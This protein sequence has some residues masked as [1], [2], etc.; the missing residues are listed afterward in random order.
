MT[1]YIEKL[2]IEKPVFG[3][4]GLGFHEG[5]AVFVPNALIGDIVRVK[6]K[7]SKKG[8]LFG[9]IEDYIEHSP[10]YTKPIC[11]VFGRCG[12]C[13]WLNLPYLKQ[14]EY[15]TTIVKEILHELDFPIKAVQGSPVSNF[16][17]NKSFLPISGS[18]KEPKIGMFAGQTHDVIE[19]E[20]C[21]LH[22]KVFDDIADLIKA[23]IIKA[24]V[25][26]YDE[27]SGKG[28]LRHLGIRYSE[29]TGQI[30][31]ILV[32][33]TK[34]LPFTKQLVHLLQENVKNLVGV[35]QN[36]NNDPGNRIM[37][38][39]DIVLYGV[40]YIE[41]ELMGKSF[42][43]HYQSFFQ[44]NTSQAE[45]MLKF[46]AKFLQSESILVDAFC[47][48][49]SIGIALSEYCR[50]VIG[51]ETVT[52][53]VDDARENAKRNKIPNCKYYCGTVEHLLPQIIKSSSPDIIIFDPPRKG[54][55][56]QTVQ[57]IVDSTIPRIIYIS[58]NPSTQVRDLKLM[59]KAGYRLVEMQAFDMF[60]H[61]WHIENVAYLERL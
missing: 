55:D 41:E 30:I 2:V 44:V 7:Y 46:A 9:D 20:T 17:R 39:E 6:I 19:H 4:Y 3:G 51:I 58:C 13:N 5:H 24:N 50:K 61:T 16:Y 21:M 18:S 49:G 38:S 35:V 12:G 28:T 29:R 56:A 42:R 54:L 27:V 32:T 14:L 53:A 52:Q 48:T 59:V 8:S 60:P 40:P 33:K 23:Y 43:L 1:E 36:I 22:P 37:G 45:A 25:S 57:L 26:I 15:K 34:K 31:V 47:G 11:E 10:D